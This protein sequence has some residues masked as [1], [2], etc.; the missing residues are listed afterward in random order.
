MTATEMY[1]SFLQLVNQ[2][3]SR[4]FFTWEVGF[5]LNRGQEELFNQLYYPEEQKRTQSDQ[6]RTSYQ[7]SAANAEMMLPFIR[8][9][10]AYTQPNGFLPLPTTAITYLGPNNTTI[11]PDRPLQH[12]TLLAAHIEDDCDQ[13]FVPVQAIRDGEEAAIEWDPFDKPRWGTGKGG[14]VTY[15]PK[16]AFYTQGIPPTLGFLIKPARRYLVTL[17]YVVLPQQIRIRNNALDNVLV[18]NPQFVSNPIDVNCEFPDFVHNEIVR[19]AVTLFNL[20]TPD[21]T[22]YQAEQQRIASGT[23]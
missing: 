9:I 12:L 7:D 14:L 18:G 16:Y 17:K 6:P 20:S 21:Y 1:Q 22:Q 3:N 23:V 2:T 13:P 10:Q 15:N 19:R 8:S 11:R 4:N 5:F